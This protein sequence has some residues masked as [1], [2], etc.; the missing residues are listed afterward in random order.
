MAKPSP[1][2]VRE[3]ST[4][5]HPLE[6]GTRFGLLT[7]IRRDGHLHGSSAWLCQC[8]CGNTHRVRYTS[9]RRGE[10]VSCGCR[11]KEVLNRRTH[12]MKRTPEWKAWDSAKQRTTNPNHKSYHDYGGRGIS[13]CDR[14][15]DN[16]EAFYADMGPRPTLKHSLDRYPDQ[17]GD[18]EP[19]NCRWATWTEQANNKRNNRLLTVKGQTMTI[20]EWSRQTGLSQSCLL[21]RLRAGRSEDEMLLPADRQRKSLTAS[22][23]DEVRR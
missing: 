18:Y 10:I 15:R 16:F 5:A 14:W 3:G 17:N 9:L 12:G 19:G 8:A 13:M 2:K 22:G 11:K 1:I 6:P 21:Q 7:V 4:R 23:W 20:P